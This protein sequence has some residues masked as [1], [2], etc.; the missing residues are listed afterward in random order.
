MAEYDAIIKAREFH[1][2]GYK[3]IFSFDS[4]VEDFLRAFFRNSCVDYLNF[5]TLTDV[6]TEFV[7]PELEKG[8]VDKLWRVQFREQYAHLYILF[9]FQSNLDSQMAFRIYRYVFRLY[10][11]LNANRNS[12]INGKL[13]L[14]LPVVLYNG[15]QTW[16]LHCSLTQMLNSCEPSLSK[17]QPQQDYFLVDMKNGCESVPLGMNVI[18]HMRQMERA[19]TKE[20]AQ[21]RLTQIEDML[22]EWPEDLGKAINIWA[23][24]KFSAQLGKRHSQKFVQNLDKES[25]MVTKEDV[26][27]YY[28]EF[29]ELLLLQHEE[30]LLEERLKQEEER[31]RIEKGVILLT[32]RT[33]FTDDEISELFNISCD[34]LQE[35]KGKLLH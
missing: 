31:K 28:L 22:S 23:W 17:F 35:I 2:R 10:D 21:R 25:E 27:A 9:E 30:Y 19:R 24:S 3:L 26:H 4:V 5:E 6:S 11:R 20:E 12:I 33:D 29:R 14:V 16:R 15:R 32:K 8:M 34:E 13:P 1:D 18:G 7:G